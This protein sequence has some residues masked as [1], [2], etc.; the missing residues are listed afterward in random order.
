[1][2]YWKRRCNKN[3]LKE[4]YNKTAEEISPKLKIYHA[5]DTIEMEDIP[6]VAIKRKKESSMVVGFNLLKEGKEMCLFLLEIPVLFL[7]ELPYWLAE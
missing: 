1:M 7:L 6:T 4:F 5:P 2:A 3:K